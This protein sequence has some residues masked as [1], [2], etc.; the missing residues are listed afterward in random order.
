ME[1]FSPAFN[2]L[3]KLIARLP[4]I[5]NK[6]AGRLAFHILKS[7]AHYAKQLSD[8]LGTLHE[9]IGFCSV[10][11]LMTE[12][13][14]CPVCISMRRD[15]SRLCVV[16]NPSDALKIESTGEYRGLYH[17]LMGA[18]SPLNRISADDLRIN[19][20]LQRLAPADSNRP[21]EEHSTIN[22]VI[23]ATNPT[24]EGDTTA[25]YINNLL[26]DYPVKITRLAQGL[27]IGGDLEF[28]DALTLSRALKNRENF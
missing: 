27:P 10:C 25:M 3:V 15:R 26:K 12:Q 7:P 6:T 21:A 5:G 13:D 28:A 2:R 14:P 4:G 8:E 23:L 11:G 17:V 24:V 16:E 20:L 22:E 18:I 19:Q 1:T 9:R